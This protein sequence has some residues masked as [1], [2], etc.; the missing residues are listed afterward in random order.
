MKIRT[1]RKTDIILAAVVILAAICAVF[2]VRATRAHG[3]DVV[4]TVD[5]EEQF[6]V[7]IDEDC[8]RDIVTDLGTNHLSVSGGIARVTE[9]DCPDLICVRAYSGGI[10]H[11]GETIICLPHRLVVSVEGGGDAGIDAVVN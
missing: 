11:E 4:V 10:S 1:I 2:A 5:G 6:R 8:E 7:P 3:A 9:A